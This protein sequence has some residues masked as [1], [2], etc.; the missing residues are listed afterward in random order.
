MYKV[1]TKDNKVIA[2]IHFLT[3]KKEIKNK[4][5]IKIIEKTLI[6]GSSEIPL[7]NKKIAV[8]STKDPF[9]K[10]KMNG[11]SGDTLHENIISLYIS[12]VKDWKR[13]LV[14]TMVHECSH[15]YV[16]DN[17]QWKTILDSLIS[18]GIAEIFREEIVG[19]KPAP[20]TKALTE[21]QAKEVLKKLKSERKLS[22]KVEE[23]HQELFF[24]SKDYKMWT[25]YSLG[26]QIVKKFRKKY[27]EMKWK[28]IMK[29]DFKELFRKSDF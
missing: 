27:P 22:K 13:A 15:L 9:I 16:L 24:G 6:K 21:K 11:V 19:G 5:V 20:W 1:K 17:N 28:E 10:N 7:L 2:E 25:G 23:M 12:P 26:Y 3:D 4:H 29:M 8:F 14:E 18:E